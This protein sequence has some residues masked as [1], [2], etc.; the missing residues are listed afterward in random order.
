MSFA[1][2][3]FV[4]FLATVLVLHRALP[5]R[6]GRIMLLVASYI[7]Y[8]AGNPWHCLL[9]LT[10]TTINFAAARRIDAL[11]DGRARKAILIVA[12]VATLGLLAVFKYGAFAAGSANTI[13]GALGL[14]LLPAP[15]WALPIGI[16]FFT[17]QALAYTLDV[18]FGKARSTRSF[19]ELALYVSFFPQLVAGPIERFS[20]LAPQL[21]EKRLAGPG[22]MEAGFQRILWGL[23]KKVV[24]A[25]RLGLF[26]DHVYGAPTEAAAAALVVATA[27]FALQVYMDFSAYCDIAIGAARMMGISL[28]E[29]F[30]WPMLARNPV[31]FWARWHVTL[32]TW[33]RDYVFTALVGRR[34]PGTA[35]RLANL[36]VVMVL[37]GLWHGPAW[38]FVAFGLAAGLSIAAYEGIYL[39][40]GRSRAKPLFGGGLLASVSA[41]L[42]MHLLG[43][44]L[45]LLFRSPSLADAATI[46]SGV[47]RGGWSFNGLTAGYAAGAAAI[48][49]ACVARGAFHERGRRDLSMPAPLR[50][51]LWLALLLAILYGAVDTH[52]Q[53]IY[54]QF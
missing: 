19:A 25:D 37:V 48:W 27:C 24:F 32:G 10:S 40:T 11:P 45:A 13:L 23:T 51:L 30:R 2:V 52:Q 47:A 42:L 28:T 46:A 49:I 36:V 8:G 17:F 15:E 18:Y 41:V 5:W 7:F 38:H 33:F 39:F 54:F 35:R 43:F 29:N 3:T 16:S 50:A 34:R 44:G 4:V 1:S 12:L 53:F 21:R 14:P 26:V 6:A 9:L 31:D 22:D 20:K